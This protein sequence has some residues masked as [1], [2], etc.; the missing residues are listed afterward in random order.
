MGFFRFEK[1]EKFQKNPENLQI[2]GNAIGIRNSRK[3][4]EKIPKNSRGVW[5][6]REFFQDLPFEIFSQTI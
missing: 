3:N 5:Q 1:L 2:P 4:P 6:S